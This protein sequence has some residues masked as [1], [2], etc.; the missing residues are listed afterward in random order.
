MTQQTIGWIGTG[1]MG[2]SMC[3]HII[4]AGYPV[5]VYTRTKEKA[6]STSGYGSDHGAPRPKKW[7]GRATSSS[8][9]SDIRMMWMTY[10]FPKME[11]S[12]NARP[13]IPSLLIC[14][15]R[16]HPWRRKYSMKPKRHECHALD[17]PV[18]GGDVGAREATL[19]IMVGGERETF[20]DVFTFTAYSRKDHLSYGGA[21]ARGS[22]PR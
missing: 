22:I 4:K 2:R 11:L 14:P 3:S 21:L 9:W 20:E 15:H 18:S 16:D 12:D 19:A 8:L 13:G 1:V 17:A 5:R 7:L 6:S 10:I